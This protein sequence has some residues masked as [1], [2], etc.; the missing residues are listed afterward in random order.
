VRVP[1]G[2][3]LGA[4]SAPEIALSVMAEILMVQRGATGIAISE[5]VK[6]GIK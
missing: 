5:K 3:D 1:I 6:R 2:L 4:Q